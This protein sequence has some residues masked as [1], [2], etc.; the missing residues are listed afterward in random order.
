MAEKK[1]LFR[2]E[3]LEKIESP[4]KM[5]SFVRVV[6]PGVWVVLAAALIAIAGVIIWGFFGTIKSKTEV[7]FRADERGK[8]IV[9]VTED[10]AKNLKRGDEI[11]IEGISGKITRVSAEA[12]QAEDYTDGY[13]VHLNGMEGAWVHELRTNITVDMGVHKAEIIKKIITPIELIVG[14]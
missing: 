2:Q 3:S 1:Q 10:V 8:A 7:Y 9:Y 13:V 6:N 11:Q 12:V 5:D 4:E 14:E